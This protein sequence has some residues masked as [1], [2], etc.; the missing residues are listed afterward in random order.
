MAATIQGVGQ[1]FEVGATVAL[2]QTQIPGSG[3]IARV[4]QPYAVTPDGRRFLINVTADE[5][6]TSPITIVTNWTRALKK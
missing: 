6:T 3:S 2:F 5:A 1:T 4:K